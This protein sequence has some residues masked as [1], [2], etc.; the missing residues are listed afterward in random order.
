MI[1]MEQMNIWRELSTVAYHTHFKNGSCG[2]IVVINNQLGDWHGNKEE[3]WERDFGGRI[4]RQSLTR[5]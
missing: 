2:C 4:E 3:S 1:H 5:C